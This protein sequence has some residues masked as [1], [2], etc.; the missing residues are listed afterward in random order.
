VEKVTGGSEVGLA[1]DNCRVVI[2][3]RDAKPNA[4]G[5][6]HIILQPRHARYLANLLTDYATEAEGNCTYSDANFFGG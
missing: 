6:R 1:N 5:V 3:Y 2:N 4:S